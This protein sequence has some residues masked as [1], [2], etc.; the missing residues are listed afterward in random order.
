MKPIRDEKSGRI[1]LRLRLMGGLLFVIFLAVAVRAFQLQVLE[2][3]QL[4]GLG[5]KQHLQEWIVRPKRGSILGRDGDPLA[6][7]LEAQSVYVRPQRLESHGRAVPMLAGALE[8]DPGEI[9]RLIGQ[10]KPF[11]WLRRQVTPR[12]AKRVTALRLKGVGMY[13]EA[14]R[15]YPR[16]ALAGHV[17]GLA[18]RDSQGLEGVERRYDPYIRGEEGASVVERD[19]LGRRVLAGGFETLS[20]P[21]GAD[22]QL[23]IDTSLQHLSEKYLE[24]TVKKY[25][26]KAGTVIMVD[27][28]SGEVLAM[29]NYPAFDPNNYERQGSNR[30]R[31]RAITDTYEPGST[32][33]AIL[34]AAAL[35]EGIVGEEDLFFCE[36]GRYRYGGR[37]I[38]DTKKHGWLPFARVIQYSSNIGVTKV[39]HRLRKDRYYEYIERFGFGEH[40]GIDLPGEVVGILRAPKHWYASDLAAHSFGQAL[41]VTPL[42]MAMAYAAIANG[43]YLMR[44]YVVQQ[45]KADNGTVLLRHEPRVVRRVISEETARVLTGILEGAVEPGATGARAALEGFRIAGKTGTSQKADLVRGGYSATKRVASFIGFAPADAP[46][47]VLLALIDEPKTNVHGGVVAAPL[48]NRIMDTTLKGMG[49]VPETQPDPLLEP[50]AGVPGLIRVSHTLPVAAVPAAIGERADFVGLSM[51]DAVAKAKELGVPVQLVG[52][53]YVV[54]QQTEDSGGRSRLVLT[55]RD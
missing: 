8:M 53:G 19:A 5:E 22:V 2:G 30:W 6:I 11:V 10:D 13:R 28:F 37:I 54:R 47:A 40:T 43:G 17:I 18:G 20:V 52:H 49:I 12:Q 29:A 39:A 3:E 27:P 26:A 15:Y 55:L 35:E 41:A 21:G 24:A 34:A 31:N 14:K 42:Q 9:R 50:A 16:G 32:F 33:K 1:R 7:S 36:L 46:R 51:R 25:G 44:P 38:R 4:A 23:T 48:F 45:V